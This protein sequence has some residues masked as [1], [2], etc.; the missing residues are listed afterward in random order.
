MPP[1]PRKQDTASRLGARLRTTWHVFPA[2]LTLGL[3]H[4]TALERW[5]VCL[6]LLPPTLLFSLVE[7]L[8]LHSKAAE[9]VFKAVLGI[10]LRPHEHAGVSGTCFYLW[11]VTLCFALPI[12]T[13]ASVLG[14]LLLSF[15]DPAAATVGRSL[16]SRPGATQLRAGKSLAGFLGAMLMGCVVVCAHTTHL[17]HGAGRE[18]GAGLLPFGLAVG[19]CAAAVETYVGFVDDNLVIPVLGAACAS[20]IAGVFGAGWQ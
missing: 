8:R 1:Q 18:W 12:E 2:L 19:F 9:R 6:L 3:Y 4:Y 20:V 13:D 16:G 15:C 7:V 14:V 17:R 5:D 10:I 11:G